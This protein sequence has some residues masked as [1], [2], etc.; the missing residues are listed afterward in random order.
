[1]RNRRLKVIV[2]LFLVMVFSCNIPDTVVTNIVNRDGSVT[3]IIEMKNSRNKFDCSVVQVPYDSTWNIRDSLEIN[4]GGDTTWVRRAWKNFSNTAEIN[5]DYMADSSANKSV[6]RR[7]E[8]SKKFRWF[9]TV[10]RYAEII[11]KELQSGYPVGEFLDEDEQ[12]WFYSPEDVS[13]KKLNGPD[14]LT[15]RSLRDTVESKTERWS[16]KNIVSLWIDEFGA[17]AER[18]PGN[19]INAKSL[20]SRED[21]FTEIITNDLHNFDSLWTNGI[22]LR[23]F[24][25]PGNVEEYRNEADSA[26][27]HAVEKVLI[28]F[29]SYSMRMILPGKLMAANGYQD[30]TGTVLWSVKSDYFLTET[31]EMWAESRV[32]HV[33]AWALTV[34]LFTFLIAA[35]FVWRKKRGCIRKPV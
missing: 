30:S 11:D 10:Y 2:A 5:R 6:S 4:S 33:W 12:L 21:E 9:S 28:D 32:S 20:K 34:L 18:K 15:Y 13:E 16:V 17:L 25:G 19:L 23:K 27:T 29:S 24:I 14:S 26:F 22:L 1:M 31:Y 8:F 3:R 35:S 7:S